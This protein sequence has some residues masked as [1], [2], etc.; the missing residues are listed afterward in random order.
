[1]SLTHKTFDDYRNAI[2]GHLDNVIASRK[3]PE[4]ELVLAHAF[5]LY[6]FVIEDM[7]AK[8]KK[9][10]EILDKTGIMLVELQDVLRGIVHGMDAVS[11]VVLA[12]LLRVSFEIRCN[13]RFIMTRR[14]PALYADRYRRFARLSELAYDDSLP[15]EKRLLKAETRADIVKTCGE[16][17]TTKPDGDLHFG[18]NWTAEKQFGSLKK[19]AEIL[20]FADEYRAS[21]SATSQY[22]HGTA[23]LFNA[24]RGPDGAIG[25]IGNTAPC[26]RMALLAARHGMRAMR[27]AARFFGL[28]LN[29]REYKV[30]LAAWLRVAKKAGA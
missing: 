10:R 11:P 9:N 26:R 1:M 24:Y 28:P 17:I 29:F 7:Q 23:L 4:C 12:T 2:V 8:S 18:H 25:P 19:R 16:W 30:W 21:Y 5:L 14:D 13:L 3:D 6:S 22:V 20:G 15:A 27:E